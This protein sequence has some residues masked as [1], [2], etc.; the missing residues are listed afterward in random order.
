MIFHRKKQFTF[1]MLVLVASLF[2]SA[3][4][5]SPPRIAVEP[6]IQELG[7]VPQQ[8]IELTYTVKN[9]GE[10]DLQILKISTSCDCTKAFLDQDRIAGGQSA[11]LTVTL[12]PTEDDLYGDV[13]RV[14]YL[15]SNDPENPEV[16]V[17]FHAVI[18]KSGEN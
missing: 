15:R 6:T 9:E 5:K 18:L 14:V 11:V 12:D 10:S 17:E 1:F 7:E 2:T 13:T 16:S 4:S 8:L 3:C